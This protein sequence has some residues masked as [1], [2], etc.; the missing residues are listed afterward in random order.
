M[1]GVR[2]VIYLILLCACTN[3]SD[4]DLMIDVIE[5]CRTNKLDK[6]IETRLRVTKY[7]IEYAATQ[8]C[9][10]NLK[11]LVET[12]LKDDNNYD[13]DSEDEYDDDCM[14]WKRMAMSGAASEGHL[15]IIQWLHTYEEDNDEE[16]DEFLDDMYPIDHAA[17]NGHLDVVK[18]LDENR[19]HEGS[20]WAMDNAAKNG[21]LEIIKYLHTH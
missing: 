18:W 2:L 9:L 8:G 12:Y 3:M 11:W 21:H 10:K 7:A 4:L 14:N 17:E 6:L 16:E 13:E 15:E 20:T 19:N 1:L 5:A